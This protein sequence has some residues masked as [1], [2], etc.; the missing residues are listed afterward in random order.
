MS[1]S[2]KNFLAMMLATVTWFSGFGILFS[3]YALLTNGVRGEEV[4]LLLALMAVF[5]GG[6][7]AAYFNKR[8]RAAMEYPYL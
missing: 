8:I 3:I 5:V 2:I 4:M 1:D 6:I 7:V